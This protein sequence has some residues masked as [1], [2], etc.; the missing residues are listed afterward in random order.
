M[1]TFYVSTRALKRSQ[2]LFKNKIFFHSTLT[3]KVNNFKTCMMNVFISKYPDIIYMFT[4]YYIISGG[5]L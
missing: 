5:A 4:R 3:L 1:Y 2:N